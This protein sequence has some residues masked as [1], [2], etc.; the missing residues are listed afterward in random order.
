MISVTDISIRAQF[1]SPCTSLRGLPRFRGSDGMHLAF[2]DEFGH[3][4]PYVSRRDKR[5]NQS[6]VF[7]LAGYILPHKEARNFA[8]FFFQLKSRMLAN[9]ITAIKKHP[10]AWEKKGNELIYTKNINKY[11]HVREGVLRLLREIDR[12]GGKVFWYGRQK[13]LAPEESNSSGLYTTVLGHAIRNIDAYV[14]RQNSQF[15]MILDQ[16]SDRLKLIETA[17]KTMFSPGN[18]ARTL[19]EPPFEV[20]SHLYQTIQAADWIATLVGRQQAY[21]VASSEYA[22]WEWAERY[23]G[24][25]VT[26]LST[27][28]KMWT[29]PPREKQRTL[30]LEVGSVASTSASRLIP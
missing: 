15:M 16:H 11:A 7:G 23:Y 30:S 26:A 14:Q 28:S 5:F 25:K 9:E 27:H 17:A 22:D 1:R 12:R 2:L 20:E 6:P 24:A 18:P 29:P 4:G 19:I 13:Y 21:R 3:C 10:A 8:T